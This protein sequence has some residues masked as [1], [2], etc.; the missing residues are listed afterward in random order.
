[1]WG[2][3]ITGAL[4]LLLLLAL[5][6][7]DAVAQTAFPTDNAL[8][9]ADTIFVGR[10]VAVRHLHRNRT[11]H[12]Q[13]IR[14]LSR[15]RIKV[16]VGRV[17]RGDAREEF[18]GRKTV[19]IERRN[20]LIPGVTLG[21]RP[22]SILGQ[23]EAMKRGTDI[24]VFL[25]G[26]STDE[27]TKP[28]KP[29]RLINGAIQDI[30]SLSAVEARIAEAH[31]RYRTTRLDAVPRCKKPDTFVLGDTCVGRSD[32]LDAT[33]CEQTHQLTQERLPR[34]ALTLGCKDSAGK[35]Q[36]QRREWGWNGELN[37]E[38]EY[39][40]GL[41]HGRWRSFHGGTNEVSVKGQMERGLKTGTWTQLNRKGDELGSY[42]MV[43]GTGTEILWTKEGKPSTQ[44][45]Y[46][47]GLKHGH[48]KSFGKL[49]VLGYYR[50][51]KAHGL[52]VYFNEDG[53]VRLVDCVRR[54]VTKWEKYKPKRVRKCPYGKTPWPLP[55]DR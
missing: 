7:S 4:L 43:A 18:G 51:G 41:P 45:D 34:G 31:V 53:S 21:Y 23:L 19:W 55:Q 38:S 11:P 24:I 14:Y 36:G 25:R 2:A 35:W 20:P 6:N 49:V 50:G 10:V 42:T 37:V 1:M 47:R 15:Y 33:T 8:D 12:G 54:E 48:F 46:R 28:G 3:R 52:F 32:V 5:G 27:E 13:R 17:L 26:I 44:T 9:D 39:R 29:L 40:D 30:A 16:R 22:D